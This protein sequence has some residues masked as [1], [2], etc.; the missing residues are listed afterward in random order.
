MPMRAVWAA[1]ALALGA[2]ASLAFAMPPW[3]WW[4]LAFIAAALLEIAIG[5][6]SSS[7]QRL[8][9]GFAFGVGWMAMGLG[10]MWFLTAP[11]YLVATALFA[12]MF[13]FAIA[14]G[15]SGPWRVIARPA[16]LALIE[17]VR[18]AF[19]FGGVPL[20]SVAISQV[21]G[22]FAAVV[23]IIGPIGLAWVVLQIGTA[24][25]TVVSHRR[26]ATPDRPTALRLG[27]AAST[28]AI[29][30]II[31]SITVAPRG[32]DTGASLRIA[33]VQG[34]GEQGTTA[35]EV[36]TW[37]V[38]ERH[39]AA[40]AT[41]EVGDEVDLV[42]WPEN[43][44]RIRDGGFAESEIAA[45]IGAEAIRL[46]VPITVGITE[47][48]PPTGTTRRFTNAQ[49]VVEPDGSVTSRYDKVRRVPFGEYIPMRAAFEAF[50]LPIDQVPSDAV[51]GSAPAVIEIP[52]SPDDTTT[53]G[54]MI[55]W[56]VFFSD[57]LR[58][59]IDNGGEVLLNPTNGASYTGTIVQTQQIASSRLRALE[60]GRWVVQAAPTGFS[61]FISPDGTVISRSAIGEPVVLIDDVNR[62]SGLTWYMRVG[63]A[64]VIVL[65]ALVLVASLVTANR[66]RLRSDL[67]D[68]RHRAVVD[69]LDDHI[70]AESSG[71][72]LDT[73]R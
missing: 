19:P 9:I 48:M 73:A 36:P 29:M 3:G 37:L 67:D 34:G 32:V 50:G 7:R 27:A 62:R 15:P 58:D 65:L 4:P 6:R 11:G 42:L 54:V 25:G 49:V 51:A 45:D 22:P 60:A 18:F 38:T 61:A 57:R 35:L 33:A 44:I 53:A 21:G 17:A 71:S 39:L 41:I 5:Q 30:F 69:D 72:D 14:I 40:T 20:A 47:D 16:A 66:R 23:R 56:E 70:G 43:T 12:A 31:A 68:D 2:G 26:L 13:A 46:G 52:I 10:W 59:A 28:V 55:S 64:P 63:D 8:A 1:A 24:L